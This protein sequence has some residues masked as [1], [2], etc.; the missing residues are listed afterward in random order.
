MKKYFLAI[1]TCFVITSATHVVIGQD[2]A[3]MSQRFEQLMFADKSAGKLAVAGHSHND[4]EQAIPFLTAYHAGM[5]SIEVDLYLSNDSLYAAHDKKDIKEGRTLEKLYLQP[6]AA[7]FKR[8]QNHPFADSTKNLQLLIDFKEDYTRLMAPLLAILNKYNFMFDEKHAAH[9]VRIVI[10]GSMPPPEKFAE[11]P[12]WLRFDGRPNITYTEAQRK[13]LGMISQDLRA[14]ADWNGKGEPKVSEM[15]AIMN[16]SRKAKDWNIPFRLW[17]TADNANSWLVLEKMGVKW[18][19]TDHPAE[20]QLYLKNLN[21][22]R[23]ELPQALETYVPT[24]KSDGHKSKIKNVIL[25]IGDG[26]GLGHL[27]AA[28][29]ANHGESNISQMHYIGFSSTTSYSLGNTDSGAG[30]TAIATGTKTYNGQI[31][32][33]TSGRALSAIPELL[34][35]LGMRSAIITTGDVSDATPAVFYAKNK[36]REAS[37]E[38]MAS[39]FNNQSI[40]LLIGG[41]PASYRESAKQRY[42][43]DQLAE[44]GFGLINDISTFEKSADRKLVLFLPDSLTKPVKDGRKPV[45]SS[46]LNLTAQKFGKHKDGFFMMAESA[47]IDWGGHARDLNYVATETLDFDQA[48]GEALRFADQNGET[49]VIVTADHETGALSLLDI[50]RENGKVQANFASND[51]SAMFVPVMAYGPHADAF[52]GFYENTEIFHRLIKLLKEQRN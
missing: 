38:I 14:Y 6:L 17:G 3:S 52:I 11:F 40:D 4:Y 25:L 1:A 26:M 16:D 5:E 12:T 48:V 9:P 47:Q 29:A 35:P 10:S 39:L 34:K 2:N 28:I 7:E 18:L 30:G 31:S 44:N 41:A 20:L 42:F 27:Q 45:L 23:F 15:Q 32:V 36:D 13:Y 33:D 8:N 49:L 24:Y 51:H 37:E 21:A 22:S 46:L 19:N 43:K 50:D